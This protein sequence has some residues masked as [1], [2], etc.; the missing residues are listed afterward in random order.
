[1]D[2]APRVL[3]LDGGE[4]GAAHVVAEAA[5]Q[6]QRPQ[7]ALPLVELGLAG[8]SRKKYERLWAGL[9]AVRTLVGRGSSGS[10]ARLE[11]VGQPGS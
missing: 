10:M 2:T 4:G 8:E 6:P 1:M 9:A 7:P 5:V 11:R 3:D